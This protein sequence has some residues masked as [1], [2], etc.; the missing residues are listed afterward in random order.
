M[1]IAWYADFFGRSSRRSNTVKTM[2]QPPH[3]RVDEVPQMHALMRAR[4]LAALVSAGASGLYATGY[5]A[6]SA[7]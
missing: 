6:T 4:P 5:A 2:Y 7:N 1:N 3:D